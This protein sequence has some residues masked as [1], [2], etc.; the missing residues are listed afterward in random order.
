MLGQWWKGMVGRC[1]VNSE[2]GDAGIMVE[3][4]AG[5]MVEGDVGLTVEGGGDAGIMVAGD[6]NSRRKQKCWNNSR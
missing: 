5:S 6:V 4:D 1:W 2:A 3:G